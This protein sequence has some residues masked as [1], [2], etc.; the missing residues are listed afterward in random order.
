MSAPRS[1]RPASADLDAM[2]V[3]RC[4]KTLIA[5]MRLPL[6]AE[7]G[8]SSGLLG[9]W[10]A[11]V[12]NVGRSRWNL[13][14]SERTLLPVIVRGR[15]DDFPG[16]FPGALGR[17]LDA[18]GIETKRVE[19]EVNACSAEVFSTTQSRVVLGVMNDFAFQV[20]V[21]AQPKYWRAGEPPTA[22]ELALDLA[23]IPCSPL[24]YDSPDRVVRALFDESVV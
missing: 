19:N 7:P 14:A 16:S 15:K 4:T 21:R 18:I 10:Y 17:V 20:S 12:L 13:C 22:L 8:A 9:D 2:V 3:F 23:K 6:A 5:R 24:G 1:S 11:N